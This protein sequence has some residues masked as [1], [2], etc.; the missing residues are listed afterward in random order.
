MIFSFYKRISEEYS[1]PKWSD[2]RRSIVGRGIPNPRAQGS[3]IIKKK[4][5][6]FE[7]EDLV[8]PGGLQTEGLGCQKAQYQKCRHDAEKRSD[9]FRKKCHWDPSFN[10][11]DKPNIQVDSDPKRCYAAEKKYPDRSKTGNPGSPGMINMTHPTI[12]VTQPIK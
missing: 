1:L 9:H 4:P 2:L 11:I 6:P 3:G 5:H 12:K 7:H 10:K 8:R